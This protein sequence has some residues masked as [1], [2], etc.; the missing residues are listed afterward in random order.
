MR[1]RTMLHLTIAAVFCGSGCRS[2]GKPEQSDDVPIGDV[3]PRRDDAGALPA[4]A[5]TID[6]LPWVGPVRPDETNADALRRMIESFARR[7]VP[8][9]GFVNC[10]RVGAGAPLLRMW[11]EA[12]LELGNHSAEHL[13]LNDAPLEEWLRDVR[14]CDA[15]VRDVSARDTVWFR[16]PYLHQGATAER[17]AAALELLRELES[18]IAHV[19]IDNSDWIL[20]VAYGDAVRAGDRDRAA[21]VATAFVEH[22]LAATEHYR[23]VATQKLGRDIPHVLL[24]HANLLV[25]D[26]VGT[27]LDSLAARG[28]RF[29]SMA[30]AQQDSAYARRD[31]YTG[32][33]GLSW[34]YRMAPATPE[35]AAWDD[36]EAGR[37]RRRWR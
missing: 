37:L 4:I 17:Q 32:P 18:P 12:G 3:A 26:H 14:R 30:A 29:V 13:D 25:A 28:F 27:L 8:A 20:A 34:L 31:A 23:S 19:T 1:A 35:L 33:D 6:D 9:H 36:A 5:I 7:T 21:D 24:L 22:I 15:Y 11:L 2:D 10:G 16:Y